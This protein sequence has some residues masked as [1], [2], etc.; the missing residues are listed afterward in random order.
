MNQPS[1][2][3]LECGA[4]SAG[5]AE[6]CARCGAPVDEPPGE[7]TSPGDSRRG[8]LIWGGGAIAVFV[9]LIAVIG[10]TATSASPANQSA[11]QLTWDQL[12]PGDCLAGSDMGLGAGGWWPDLVTQVACTQRHEAEVF[13][14]GDIWPQSLA[15]P[16]DT[17][18]GSQAYARCT[19][20]F[21]AYD[22][23]DYGQSSFQVT[24]IVP[25]G[26]DWD[27][28]DRSLACLAYEASSSG[29]SGGT[30]V[31]YSIRGSDD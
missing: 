29:P 18:L 10:V 28:G 1:S 31:D 17:A 26:P 30:P 19:A 14:V 16:G 6:I 21:P 24:S 4:E 7:R 2:Q 3:C 5:A 8:N 11:N 13:F 22:G 15:Y 27:A 12:Q 9:A 23:T 20:A 25:G